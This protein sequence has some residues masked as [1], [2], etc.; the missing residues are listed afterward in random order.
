MRIYFI[1]LFFSIRIFFGFLATV[2]DVECMYKDN[3][4]QCH[5]KQEREREIG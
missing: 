2:V 3:D 4:E 5:Y 1:K